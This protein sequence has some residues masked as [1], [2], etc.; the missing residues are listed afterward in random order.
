MIPEERADPRA[1]FLSHAPGKAEEEEIEPHKQGDVQKDRDP[2][3]PGRAG[4]G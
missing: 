4:K 1:L 2:S 3:A